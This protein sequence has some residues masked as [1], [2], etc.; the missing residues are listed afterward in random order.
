MGDGDTEDKATHQERLW[1]GHAEMSGR[2][3]YSDTGGEDQDGWW[4]GK[5]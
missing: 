4:E 3:P 5:D 2:G 1:R